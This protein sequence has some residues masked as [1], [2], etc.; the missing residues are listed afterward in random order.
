MQLIAALV[1]FGRFIKGISKHRYYRYLIE[2]RFFL[3]LI[4]LLPLAA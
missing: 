1:D 2:T 4:G 3:N